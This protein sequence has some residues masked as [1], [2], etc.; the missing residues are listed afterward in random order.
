MTLDGCQAQYCVKHLVNV[1][2]LFQQLL[3]PS[4]F[5]VW[6]YASLPFLICAAHI[7][8]LPGTTAS[9]ASTIM[10]MRPTVCQFDPT[11]SSRVSRVNG[12]LLAGG[13]PASHA[14]TL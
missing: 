1:C 11:H 12:S 9:M 3:L 13:C 6:C 4:A 8:V 2:L 10:L 5:F 7:T 14:F